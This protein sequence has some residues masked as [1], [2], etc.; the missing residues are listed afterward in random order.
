MD[1]EGQKLADKLHQIITAAFGVIGFIYGYLQQRFGYTMYISMVGLCISA[2]ICVPDWGFL[3]RNPLK[4]QKP[5]S[6]EGDRVDA[7]EKE[8]NERQGEAATQAQKAQAQK[9]KTKKKS[10]GKG[11]KSKKTKR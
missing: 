8:E 1:F 11:G 5:L 7:D 6:E 2:I 10:T 4:W 3:N 9:A